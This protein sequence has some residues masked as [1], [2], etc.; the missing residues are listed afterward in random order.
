MVSDGVCVRY[1]STVR[2][3]SS[4]TSRSKPVLLVMDTLW[5]PFMGFLMSYLRMGVKPISTLVPVT[6]TFILLPDVFS[7]FLTSLGVKPSLSLTMLGSKLW[8]GTW[9]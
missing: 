9:M 2:L 3:E 5:P 4:S 6:S 1:T 8:K 7:S